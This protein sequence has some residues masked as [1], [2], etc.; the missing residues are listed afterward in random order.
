MALLTVGQVVTNA[1]NPRALAEFYSKLLGGTVVELGNGYVGLQH[2]EP[3]VWFL[4]QQA[5]APVQQAGW[6]HC[7]C[8]LADDKRSAAGLA[9]A[10]E[11]IEAAGGKLVE[12]RADS[13]F[14]W[15][16]MADPEGNPFCIVRGP[17]SE[18]AHEWG[19]AGEHYEYELYGTTN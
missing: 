5:D 3:V 19:V 14:V 11:V 6:V 17:I 4:F 12:H 2:D 18:T 1:M 7:D 9:E 10:I 16:V 15:T 13:N 8:L